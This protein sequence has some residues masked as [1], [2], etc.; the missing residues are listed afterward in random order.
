MSCTWSDTLIVLCSW[1]ATGR[2]LT[3]LVD[4]SC[5]RPRR[6]LQH[7]CAPLSNSRL[8]RGLGQLP[9][10]TVSASQPS[11]SFLPTCSPANAPDIHAQR[12]CARS[13]GLGFDTSCLF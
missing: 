1:P 9:V 6:I 3:A 13:L 4:T 11:L 10:H 7:V 12:D 8:P 5:R 2:R